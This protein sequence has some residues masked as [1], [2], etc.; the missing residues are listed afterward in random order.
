MRKLGVTWGGHSKGGILSISVSPSLL[1][2]YLTQDIILR[3]RL[4]LN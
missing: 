4:N 1:I 2:I 3:S